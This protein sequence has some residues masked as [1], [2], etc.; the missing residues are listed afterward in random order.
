[1][2]NIALIHTQPLYRKGLS[3]LLS[4]TID[5]FIVEGGPDS[6]LTQKP[7][8]L[9]LARELGFKLRHVELF[10]EISARD[11]IDQRIPIRGNIIA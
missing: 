11:P 9:E 3:I 5:D 8:A 4:Q 6:F 10:N 7:W 2:I 1:M